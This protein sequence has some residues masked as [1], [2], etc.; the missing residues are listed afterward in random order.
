[1]ATGWLATSARADPPKRF[2][3]A[4]SST[5]STSVFQAPQLGHLPCHLGSTPPHSVQV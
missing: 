2:F 3:G 4:V 1:V 5:D